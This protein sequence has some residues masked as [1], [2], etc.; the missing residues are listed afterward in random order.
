MEHFMKRIID[1]RI[2]EKFLLDDAYLNGQ[3]KICGWQATLVYLS[4]CRHANKE[5]ESFP[6]IRLMSEELAVGRN[7]IIKGITNLERYNVIQT[8]KRRSKNGK[9]LNNTYILIDKSQWIR[10]QVPVEDLDSRVPVGTKPSPCGNKTKSSTRTLR[11]HIEGNTYKETHIVADATE[12]KSFSF[13]EK[14]ESMKQN[15]DVRMS[16][17]AIYWEI[18]EITA[19]NHEQY[20]AML[21]RELR[22]ATDLKGYPLIKI[23]KVCQWLKENADFKWTLETVIKYINEDLIK[24]SANKLSTPEREKLEAE[25]I[26]KKYADD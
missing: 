12:K 15:E 2:K 18:K 11:K 3:A 25:L 16:I 13:K 9:W 5:Q 8:E 1:R 20:Q 4:L 7:T 10:S 24:L 6:S 26:R 19:E 17:I 22:P 14:I 21:R 23:E